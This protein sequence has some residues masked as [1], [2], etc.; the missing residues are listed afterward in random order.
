MPTNKEMELIREELHYKGL[1]DF[2][3]E[4]YWSIV[5]DGDSGYAE[6]WFFSKDGDGPPFVDEEQN[7]FFCR[8][9]R[10]K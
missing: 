9:V 1:G 3:D 10:D 4:M 7:A 6:G 2:K 5:Q 8:P